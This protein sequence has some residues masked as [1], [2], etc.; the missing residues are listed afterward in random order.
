MRE[1]AVYAR[2]QEQE[3][4][5]SLV[6]SGGTQE[7]KLAETCIGTQDVYINKQGLP[8]N[9][10]SLFAPI[11]HRRQLK[12]STLFKTNQLDGSWTALIAG[13]LHN[14]PVIVRAGYPWGRNFRRQQGDGFKADLI[15]RIEA[16]AFRKATAIIV[17]TD[18]LKAYVIEKSGVETDRISVIPNYVDTELFRPNPEQTK[19]PQQICFVGRLMPVKNLDLLCQAVA[20]IPD[21]TLVLVGDGPHRQELESWVQSNGVSKRI[22]FAGLVPN[23]TLPDIIN[24]SAIFALTSK[25]EGHPKALIEA[26]ACEIAPIGTDVPG[27]RNLLQHEVNGLLCQ[28]TVD[29]IEQGLRRLFDDDNLRATLSQAAYAFAKQEY[30]LDK[31]VDMELA[32]YETIHQDF[33]G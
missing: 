26:M 22:Q 20:R 21:A 14:K 4:P 18:E 11:L 32:L 15:E 2:F 28:P 7:Y 27:I 23:E 33:Y 25:F 10:Y 17:T 3:L 30:S 12:H 13:W 9:L 6:S 29:G 1:C 31:V 8:A 19:N 24:Q 5:V 16:F